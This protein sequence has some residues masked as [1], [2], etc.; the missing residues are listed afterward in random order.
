MEEQRLR[1]VDM[2]TGSQCVVV[3]LSGYGGFRHRLMELGFVR[4]E[5][6]KVIKNAPLHD[7]I[8]YEIMQSH[9]SL[10]RFEA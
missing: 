1:L 4:G 7:P 10:R 6:V 8:E 9:F 2:P 3:K 5:K